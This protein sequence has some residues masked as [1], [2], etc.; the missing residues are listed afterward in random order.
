MKKILD[1]V[2]IKE[3][4]YPVVIIL[5]GIMAYIILSKSIKG[6]FRLRLNRMDKRRSK[7]MCSLINNIPD[8]VL[9]KALASTN[10]AIFTAEYIS[11][12]YLPLFLFISSILIIT[13]SIIIFIL[14]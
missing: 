7:T 9:L 14:L 3:V 5:I 6:M 13:L 2:L 11:S 8:E 4:V 10:D 12:N 1:I